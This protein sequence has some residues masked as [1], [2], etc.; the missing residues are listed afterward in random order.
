MILTWEETGRASGSREKQKARGNKSFVMKDNHILIRS[1]LRREKSEDVLVRFINRYCNSQRSSW[2]FS[3][4]GAFSL[5]RR[6]SSWRRE[7]I[8]SRVSCAHISPT[9]IILDSLIKRGRK[10]AIYIVKWTYPQSSRTYE[11]FLVGERR[12]RWNRYLRHDSWNRFKSVVFGDS[13]FR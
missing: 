13:N 7:T 1:E 9:H 10:Y 11:K 6:L 3:R 5:D 8:C 2:F 4:R 12:F